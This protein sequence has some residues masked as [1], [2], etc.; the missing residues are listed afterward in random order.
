MST[1]L[2]APGAKKYRRQ[3][4]KDHRG[5]LDTRLAWLFNQRF[6]TVQTVWRDT[7]DELDRLAAMMLIQAVLGK[8]LNNIQLV[9]RRL[10]GGPQEDQVILDDELKL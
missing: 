10:E 4:P 6:G 8:D 9:Y 7:D 3:V 5:S 1:E 2:V